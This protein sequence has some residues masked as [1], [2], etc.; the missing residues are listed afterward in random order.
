MLRTR[1][2][3]FAA[4]LVIF[5][6]LALGRVEAQAPLDLRYVPP[7]ATMVLAASTPGI[8]APITEALRALKG[9]D[10]RETEAKIRAQLVTVFGAS[11]DDIAQVT[12][13]ALRSSPHQDVT[14]IRTTR[15]HDFKKAPGFFGDGAALKRH[16]GKVYHELAG[17]RPGFFYFP[18]DRTAIVAGMEN[19]LHPCIDAGETGAA[20]SALGKLWKDVADSHLAIAVDVAALRRMTPQAAPAAQIF[21]A[22]WEKSTVVVVGTTHGRDAKLRGVAV[23][24]DAADAAKVKQGVEAILPAA[25]LGVAAGRQGLAADAAMPATARSLVGRALDVAEGI[26]TNARV[27]QDDRSVRLNVQVQPDPAVAVG[28]AWVLP[29]LARV[30]RPAP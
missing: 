16:A 7:K 5:G 29:A 28:A 8:A 2:K 14:I 9:N 3:S 6:T 22:I 17:R 26:V 30:S 10:A 1:R 13:V 27:E 20:D 11:A 21:G 25:R 24:A 18:D 12:A 15:P 4:L 23:C 19:D